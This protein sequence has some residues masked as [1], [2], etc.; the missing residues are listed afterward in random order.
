M[1]D[2]VFAALADP[3]RREMLE[4]LSQKGPLSTGDLLAD[5]GMSRQGASRHLDVLDSS[6]LVRSVRQG[7]VV[8]R[9]LDVDKFRASVAW[10]N[11]TASA[12]DNR[13]NR[14]ADSY[15]DDK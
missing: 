10:I 12:W 2:V 7:R 1:I 5:L 9:E 15:R 4:R 13:L 6:G 8:M 14:L 3:T 11:R